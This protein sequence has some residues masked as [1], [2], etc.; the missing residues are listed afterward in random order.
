MR[1][2]KGISN[3][4]AV[5]GFIILVLA[6]GC[7]AVGAV[8]MSKF[9]DAVS[10][11]GL[12]AIYFLIPGILLV[13]AGFGRYITVLAVGI[14]ANVFGIFVALAGMI[15]AAGVWVVLNATCLTVANQCTCLGDIYDRSG[16]YTCK[17]SNDFAL[18]LIARDKKEC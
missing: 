18:F 9:N 5:F 17:L 7:I 1:L 3:A 6:V 14:G 15:Y 11:I 16:S 8:T 13:V 4:S 12:W 10:S 2:S